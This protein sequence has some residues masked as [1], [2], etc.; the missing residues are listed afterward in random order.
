[1][2]ASIKNVDIFT[3][4]KN[5]HKKK[6]NYYNIFEFLSSNE[7]V[8]IILISYFRGHHQFIIDV[9]ITALLADWR[10]IYVCHLTIDCNPIQFELS[11]DRESSS[12]TTTTTTFPRNDWHTNSAF[13][14]KTRRTEF[15]FQVSKISIGIIHK[16][17][18]D[19]I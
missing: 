11:T 10:C 16:R 19:R 18:T 6:G 12:N 1:M 8:I 7:I 4:G 17:H 5:R 3:L 14:D 13:I 9:F 15:R 2:F